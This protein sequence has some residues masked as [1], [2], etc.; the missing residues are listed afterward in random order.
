[1]TVLDLPSCGAPI[2]Y[3]DALAAV[4]GYC[5]GKRPLTVGTPSYPAGITVDVPRFA[6]SVYDGTPAADDDGIA[7]LDVLVT[8]GMN[9]QL[10]QR[11]IEALL[12]AGRRAWPHMRSARDLAA[13]RSFW[14]LNASAVGLQPP[15][16]SPGEAMTKAWSE[17]MSTNGVDIA[18]A[19]KLLHH[20]LP[21]LFPLIDRQTRPALRTLAARRGVGL[22]A[23][24]HHELTTNA[25]AFDR[26]EAEVNDL[27][28]ARGHVP[29]YRLRLHDI[30]LWL[31]TSN[32]W[33]VA[34]MQGRQVLGS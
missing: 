32:H 14:E 15:A 26:L 11:V 7:P 33:D 1:M 22:W 12:D 10:D 23:V 34:S 27:L 28:L 21:C 30:L 6:Y 3:D 31:L 29:I 18:R 13:G 5:L 8:D 17:L 20:K 24:I 19:H 2:L 4:I 16:G 25:D 9:A